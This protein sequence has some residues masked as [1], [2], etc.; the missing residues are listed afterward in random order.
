MSLY[1]HRSQDLG[2]KVHFFRTNSSKELLDI[3]YQETNRL[4]GS[5]NKK[6]S[7]KTEDLGQVPASKV[8]SNELLEAIERIWALRSIIPDPTDPSKCV[9]NAK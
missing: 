9:V 2:V 3:I 4:K 8:L 1:M 6:S 5:K 7:E